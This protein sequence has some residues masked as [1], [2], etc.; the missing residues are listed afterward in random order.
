MKRVAIFVALITLCWT[1]ISSAQGVTNPIR[2]TWIPASCHTWTSAAAALILANGEPNVIVLPTAR[3]DRPWLILRRVEEGSVFVPEDEPFKCEVFDN[4]T[5]ASL[6]FASMETCHGPLILNVPDGR[7]VVASL[8]KC[9]GA[10]KRRAV[11]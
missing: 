6:A 8:A 11:N 4:V 9:D 1:G 5:Q 3:D 7:A 10:T 2:Y